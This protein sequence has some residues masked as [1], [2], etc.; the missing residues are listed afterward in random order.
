MCKSAVSIL[1]LYLL[2]LQTISAR[3]FII[4]APFPQWQFQTADGTIQ[5]IN[6]YIFNQMAKKLDVKIVHKHQPWTR[7]WLSIQRG[8][9]EAFIA[10]SRKPVGSPIY[11][12]LARD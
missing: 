6:L 2:T 4:S 1:F 5:G 8:Q 3:E 10:A 7:A 9:G 12:S 11:A